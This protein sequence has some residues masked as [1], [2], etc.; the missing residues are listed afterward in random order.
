MKKLN[1][2][3]IC[4]VVL[5]FVVGVHSGPGQPGIEVD[6]TEYDFGDVELGSSS[7]AIFTI[8]NVGFEPIFID[9]VSLDATSSA[10]FGTNDPGFNGEP[11]MRMSQSV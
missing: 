7:P 11:W 1:L 5:V 10:S 9:Q 2:A 8:T 6:L 4:A 3:A